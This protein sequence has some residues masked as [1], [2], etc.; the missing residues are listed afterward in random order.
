[1]LARTAGLAARFII[2]GE[3]KIMTGFFTTTLSSSRFPLLALLFTYAIELLW[4]PFEV[5]RANGQSEFWG[6][7]FVLDPP[8]LSDRSVII[9]R[10]DYIALEMMLTTVAIFVWY[11]LASPRSTGTH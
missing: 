3:W 11:F 1:M 8:E 9:A 2:T 5:F 6:Y 10:L 7:W 4:V